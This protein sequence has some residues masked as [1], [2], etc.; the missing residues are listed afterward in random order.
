M[1]D[2]D[3]ADHIFPRSSDMIDGMTQDEIEAFANW[4]G[5]NGTNIPDSGN[6]TT[7]RAAVRRFIC[8]A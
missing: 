6:I 4:Y 1:N 7:K 3:T 8:D 5:I 2:G